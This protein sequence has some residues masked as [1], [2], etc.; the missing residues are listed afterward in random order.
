MVKIVEN[1]KEKKSIIEKQFQQPI[2]KVNKNIRNIEIR[3]EPEGT[4][5]NVAILTIGNT[6]TA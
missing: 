2:N 5:G 1:D 4:N 6:G 3:K